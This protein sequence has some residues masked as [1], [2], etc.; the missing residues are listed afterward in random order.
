M[1]SAALA[2]LLAVACIWASVWKSLRLNAVA[3]GREFRDRMGHAIA[4]LGAFG[5]SL[6]SIKEALEKGLGKG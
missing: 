3:D 1:F 6:E 2:C 5:Q 4:Q